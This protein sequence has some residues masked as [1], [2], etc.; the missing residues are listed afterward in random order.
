MSVATASEEEP[1]NKPD[2]CMSYDEAAK[3]L[4]VPSRRL[5]WAAH[6]NRITEYSSTK[7]WPGRTDINELVFEVSLKEARKYLKSIGA[8]E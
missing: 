2:D 6:S 5:K 3:L 4:G 7:P 8:I 1:E